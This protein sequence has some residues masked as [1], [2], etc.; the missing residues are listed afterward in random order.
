MPYTLTMR[1]AL[2]IVVILLVGAVLACGDGESDADRYAQATIE[3]AIARI[4]STAATNEPSP[5][6]PT[7]IA[8]TTAPTVA[9]PT[10]AP[11]ATSPV[12]PTNSPIP[13][14]T[15]PAVHEITEVRNWQFAE[16]SAPD[17]VDTVRAVDWIADGLQNAT[18]FNAAERLLN[19]GILAPETLD[20]LLDSH[21][22]G[23]RLTAFDMPALLS[24]QRMAQDRPERLSQLT[25]A[26]WF[27]DGLTDSEAA[28]VAVL[29]ERSRFQSPEF[30]DIV[31]DPGSLNVEIQTTNNRS[32][33]T[34]PIAIVRSGPP[35]ADSPVMAT[36]QVA[37]P[38]FEAMFDA[39]FPTPAI[40]IHITDYVAGVAA[41]TN[42]QT[43]ITLKPTIDANEMPEF[44]VHSVLHEIAHYY[45]YSHPIWYAEGGADFAASYV[46][47]V[48]SGAPIE[49][50]NSPCAA[51]GSLSELEIRLPADPDATHEDANLSRCAY[52]LG[53]R[54]MLALYRH[55]GEEQF[56]QGWREPYQSLAAQPTYPV[57]Y[58]FPEVELR[59]GYLR[60]AGRLKQ[61]ELE[62]IWD[63]WYRGTASTIVEGAPD[64][65]PP[66]TNLPSVNGRIDSAHVSLT[67][68]GSETDSF[69]A[70]EQQG[71]VF[72]NLEYSYQVPS[73][74]EQRTWELVEYYQDGYAYSRRSVDVD[75]EPQY[76]GGT[77][78]LSLGPTP[79]HR[80]APGRYW[81]YVYEDGRKIAE[82][83][84]EVTP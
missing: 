41:G 19:I 1:R 65:T 20:A 46:R 38:L 8:P 11:T 48:L 84:Y 51:A 52:S 79:P 75:F 9:T 33:D 10:D 4:A 76:A 68:F 6:A 63:Q 3:A 64:P 44:A 54:L 81:A 2:S 74:A 82:V 60:A 70:S 28:I 29:Y 15:L 58:D 56:L 72:L 17:V 32:G 83:E 23:S 34:V 13:T 80:W 71:W 39:P 55:L 45:L 57:D 69:S 26:T 31:R 66:D 25:N 47:N 77:R 14:P 27:R 50:T 16:Q 62:H 73:G 35:P 36:S 43:H 24:L 5:D 30:D 12:V 59:V 37:A 22:V 61:P 21:T 18:E 42:F 40:V 78:W 7:A 53:E 67:Q 49:A